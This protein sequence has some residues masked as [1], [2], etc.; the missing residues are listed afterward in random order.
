M[1]DGA[2]EWSLA[3]KTKACLLSSTAPETAALGQNGW[4]YGSWNF[5]KLALN[6]P[7]LPTW[8]IVSLRQTTD[9]TPGYIAETACREE[10][11]NLAGMMTSPTQ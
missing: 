1:S 3:S 5:S 4:R 8:G 10:L 7:G 2:G 11:L 9:F 6:Y